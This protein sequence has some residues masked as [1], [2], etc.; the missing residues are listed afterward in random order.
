M[1]RNYSEYLRGHN[2]CAVSVPQ[3]RL[4]GLTKEE[5]DLHPGSHL[6]GLFVHTQPR[7]HFSHA[8]QE[9][10]QRALNGETSEDL[11]V[12]LRLSHWTV[13]KRWHAIYERVATA[14]SELLPPIS[15]GADSH[16]RGA[17]RRRRLLAYLRQHLE[18]LRPFRGKVRSAYMRSFIFLYLLVNDDI[19]WLLQSSLRDLAQQIQ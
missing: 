18:E 6:A 11:A 4:V 7:F 8:E 13:K 17:E 19:W 10:L 9:L 2:N 16:E 15:N 1:R 12:S 14:D 3:P 5:A